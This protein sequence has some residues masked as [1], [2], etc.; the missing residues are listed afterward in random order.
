MR[1]TTV[2]TCAAFCEG[3]GSTCLRAQANYAGGCDLR[4]P[5]NGQATVLDGCNET[6][7]EQLCVCSVTG[8]SWQQVEGRRTALQTA[9]VLATASADF[10]TTNVKLLRL[11]FFVKCF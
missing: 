10:H 8:T 3:Q 11:H 4:E 1:I 9:L 6:L 5:A 2:G 7:S